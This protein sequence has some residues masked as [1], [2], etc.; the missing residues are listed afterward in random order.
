LLL[1]PQGKEAFAKVKIK[2]YPDY[3]GRNFG[4]LL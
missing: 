2:N 4:S 1:Q 3:T